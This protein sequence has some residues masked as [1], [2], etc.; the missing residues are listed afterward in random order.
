MNTVTTLESRLALVPLLGQAGKALIQAGVIAPMS[1][2]KIWRI[3]STAHKLGTN[4][5]T[6][7]AIA[8]V[9]YPDRPA[10]ID[11]RG[12]ITYGELHQRAM[13]I[14]AALAHDHGV[15][16]GRAIGILCR[17]HRGFVEAMIASARLGADLVFLNTDFPGPQLGQVLARHD[18]TVIIHDEEFTTPLQAADYAGIRVLAWQDQPGNEYSLDVLAHCHAPEPAV[19]ARPGKIVVLTSGTTGVPKGAP[20]TPSSAAFIGPA[21]T[22]FGSTPLCT[23]AP[24]YL[25][26]PLFHGFGLAFGIIGLAIGAPIIIQ[27]RFEPVAMLRAMTE[28]RAKIAVAVPIMLQR[29]LDLPEAELAKAD[30]SPLEAMLAAAAPLSAP[31]ALRWM[32]RFGDRLFNL[33]GSSETGF[34]SIA[35]PTDLRAAPGTVGRPP[36][37]TR[38]KIMD[39]HGRE[40]P[41]GQTGH[42]CIHSAML[43][44]G[45]VGGG[46][47]SLL[48]GHMN[49][50]DLGHIDAAG[51]LFIDGREDDMI[52][53]GGENVFPQEVADVLSGH[54]AVA[55]VAVFGVADTEFGQRLK[56]FVVKRH[57][58]SEDELKTY[59]KSQIARY[60]VPRDI[61]FI[62]TMP[63]TPS[64][65]ILRKQLAC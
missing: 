21:A 55:D 27:R 3:V 18:F 51:H 64:G 32:N 17:N 14:A 6:L 58:T 15:G 4:I 23:G 37:G 53:S 50:G 7:S 44:E 12:S 8:A 34:A 56:A 49:T 16:P 36:L 40:Q 29:I 61:V 25:A 2:W 1:P 52:V 9:R 47:K 41:A 46:S 42:I 31:L 63:R 24:L 62:D 30:L 60:K 65:K 10:I 48:N 5:A 38:L 20:R 22:L 13:A 57:D 54:Q 19:P 26:P 11:E 35:T 28:H 45:Y 43:F 59:L 33:Y 39:E